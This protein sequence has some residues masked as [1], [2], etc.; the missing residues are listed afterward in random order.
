MRPCRQINKARRFPARR[1]PPKP[2]SDALAPRFVHDAY[3]FLGHS[4]CIRDSIA[5]DLPAWDRQN[6]LTSFVL[7][8]YAFGLEETGELNRAD[9]VAREAI[10][11]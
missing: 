7:G 5:R 2:T 10:A 4:L 3:L 11:R 6:P 1:R 8:Q 9:A